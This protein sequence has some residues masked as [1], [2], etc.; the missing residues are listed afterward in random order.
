MIAGLIEPESGDLLID[1]ISLR[2]MNLN[3]YRNKVGYISQ[4]PVIFSDTLYNNITFWA[5]PTAENVKRFERAVEMAS[6]KE[7]V[8]NQ[9]DKEKTRLGDNG[10]LISGGQKQRISIARELYKDVDILIFDEA[11][12]SLDSETE[13]MIQ[14]NIE[15][16]HGRYTMIVIAHR[17]S[18]IKEADIIF[19]LEKGRITDSGNFEEMM[20]KSSRFKKMVSLQEV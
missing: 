19:L 20:H 17:L 14:E 5:E 10:I 3:N 16:L 6:L 8:S 18:T 4:E 9:P 13:K 12:S 1:H 15:Q 2:E 7:F 11:T